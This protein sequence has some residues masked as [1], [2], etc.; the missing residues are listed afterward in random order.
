MAGAVLATAAMIAA[1]LAPG[2]DGLLA[3]RVAYGV[4]FSLFTM[5]I[6]A[7]TRQVLMDAFG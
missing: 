4:A 6:Q 7:H 3:A 1:A 2:A 5:G